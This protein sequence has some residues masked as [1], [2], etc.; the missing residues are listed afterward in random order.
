M[1]VLRKS[2]PGLR[3][4]TPGRLLLTVIRNNSEEVIE[5]IIV[6]KFFLAIVHYD[7]PPLIVPLV[8]LVQNLR[9]GFKKF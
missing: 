2:D 3:E 4:V 8:K 1:G 7:L 6:Q 5:T 9:K